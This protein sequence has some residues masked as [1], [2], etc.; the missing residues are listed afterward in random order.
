MRRETH[1]AQHNNKLL[2][3]VCTQIKA[4]LLQRRKMHQKPEPAVWENKTVLICF[5]SLKMC[6]MGGPSTNSVDGD[7]NHE[8][9]MRNKNFKTRK[10]KKKSVDSYH[11]PSGLTHRSPSHSTLVLFLSL[12]FPKSN[13][14]SI[15]NFQMNWDWRTKWEI[16][17]MRTNVVAIADW[18]PDCRGR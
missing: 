8:K 6:P 13:P 12:S 16:M 10:R 4:S 14:I 11:F 7:E 5:A 2:L 17:D 18:K 15:R 9:E 1:R 3:L